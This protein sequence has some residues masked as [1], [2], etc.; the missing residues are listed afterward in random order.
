MEKLFCDKLA[1]VNSKHQHA[2]KAN[3]F[4]FSTVCGYDLE[5]KVSDNIKIQTEKLMGNMIDLLAAAELT[6]NDLVKVTVYIVNFNDI[7]KMNEVYYSYFST[8][9]PMR[10]CI[11]VNNLCDGL[12]VEMEIVAAL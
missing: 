1:P 2:I 12:K 10:T 3:G 8:T 9:T 4:L 11:Q 7:D 5:G 6:L